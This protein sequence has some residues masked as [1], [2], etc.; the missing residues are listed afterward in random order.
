MKR[1]KKMRGFL[2]LWLGLASGLV[3]LIVTL[4]GSILVFEKEIDEWVHKDF[5]FV[6]P[7]GQRL[8]VDSLLASVKQ[9]DNAF[10]VTSFTIDTDAPSRSVIFYGKKKK[11]TIWIAVNPY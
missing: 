1:T 8:S 4:T 3:V 10:S 9:H 11:E 6:K 2:H 7:A 5:F